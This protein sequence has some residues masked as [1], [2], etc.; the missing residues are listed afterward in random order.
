[1]FGRAIVVLLAACTIGW[2]ASARAQEGF[3]WTGELGINVYGLSYH[4]DD[5]RAEQ[6][7]VD[8]WFNPG[9]GVRYRFAEWS[10][11]N[12]FVDAGVFEDSGREAA[13]VLGVGA[14]WHFGGGFQ[15]GGALAY[16]H[17]NTYNQGDAFIA[18]LPL[19]VWDAG[20]VALNFTYFPKIS[21]FNEVAT[22][23]FWLTFW[24]KRW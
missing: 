19:I 13:K 4:F 1:M 16:M 18:P 21:D 10:K 22:L 14:L 23:G 17:S 5:D 7:G 12:F 8:N 9:F 20:P 2:S 11:F 15:V 6:I 3:K 24:P